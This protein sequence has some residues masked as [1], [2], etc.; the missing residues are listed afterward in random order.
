MAT[1]CKLIAKTTL[2]SASSTVTLD[3][4]P[5]TY[6][7]LLVVASI[8]SAN[9]GTFDWAYIQFN[10]STA[11]FSSRYLQGDGSSATSGSN[12]ASGR[13]LG[14]INGDTSTSSSFS[15]L[16]IYIP[17]Y[18]GSTN[19][20]FSGTWAYE[21]NATTANLGVFASL[22]SNTAAITSMSFT[23]EASRN[24][25]ADSSFFLYGIKKA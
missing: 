2:G 15:S 7:D 9:N 1:T 25:K 18:A 10:S 6:D 19:K 4:I 11:N 21:T 14:T 3:N 16:E 5:A 24:Y 8:R 13:Y 17:N 12:F 20:S 22:W 23:L